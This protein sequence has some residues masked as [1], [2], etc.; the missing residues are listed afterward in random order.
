VQLKLGTRHRKDSLHT[1]W[2]NRVE[3]TRCTGQPEV[4]VQKKANIK[5]PWDESQVSVVGL[6][7]LGYGRK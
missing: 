1:R 7:A 6:L 3:N 2:R 5:V 4:K